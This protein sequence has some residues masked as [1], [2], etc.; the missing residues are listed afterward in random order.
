MALAAKVAIALIVRHDEDDVGFSVSNT[1]KQKQNRNG[2]G[3][4]SHGIFRFRRK[5][6]DPNLG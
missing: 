6:T 2:D 4:S 5:R 1:G 3:C